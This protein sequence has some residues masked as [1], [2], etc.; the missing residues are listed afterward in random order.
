MPESNDRWVDFFF[1]APLSTAELQTL[2]ISQPDF[3]RTWYFQANF[4]DGFWA[5]LESGDKV[6]FDYVPFA[7]KLLEDRGNLDFGM[8]VTLGD[9]GEILPDEIQRAREAGSLRTSPP[10]VIY[11]S[12]RSDDLEKPMFG[13]IVLQARPITR[14]SEGAQFDAT[15]PQVN[16]SKTGR[17]YRSD[18]FPMLRGFL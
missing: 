15:A 5:G 16:V 18:E 13:P 6:F 3:S 9:L 1:G 12:F 10:S 7:L 14:S 17:A 2:Q 8:T 11:R 4:R